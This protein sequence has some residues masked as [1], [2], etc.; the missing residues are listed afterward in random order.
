MNSFL[1]P[2]NRPLPPRRVSGRPR[3][4]RTT[5]IGRST[6]WWPQSRPCAPSGRHGRASW[7]A[8]GCCS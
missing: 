2:L 5:P 4:R 1:K 8:A 3:V 6:I 7:T